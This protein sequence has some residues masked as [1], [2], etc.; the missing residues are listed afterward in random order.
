MAGRKKG[1]ATQL[2]IEVT[3]EEE[4]EKLLQKEGL[5][6][7][8]V[9]TGWCGPC[10]GMLGNLKKIKL[11]IGGELL[12]MA[13][14]K[15]DEIE[16][17][18]RF[19]KKSE[20]TWMFI[21][22]GQMVN[23]MFGANAPRLCRMIVDE[24]AKETAVINGE[25]ERE[26]IPFHE[27]TPEE[28]IRNEEIERRRLEALAAEEEA[29]AAK[30]NALRLLSLAR[31][32]VDPLHLVL[33]P[34][35]VVAAGPDTGAWQELTAALTTAGALILEEHQV[36]LEPETASAA[37]DL[38]A[39]G[40]EAR[41][42]WCVAL[43][44][45]PCVA[46][47]LGTLLE[48]TEQGVTL[49]ELLKELIG[50]AVPLEAPPETLSHK[51][52]DGDH[53]PGLWAPCEPEKRASAVALLF[54]E[55]Q[56]A[57]G[58]AA[59][60]E[61]AVALFEAERQQEILAGLQGVA[62]KILAVALRQLG[63]HEETVLLGAENAEGRLMGDRLVVAMRTDGEDKAEAF[64]ALTPLY[65]SSD[66]VMGVRDFQLLFPATDKQQD[67]EEPGETNEDQTEEKQEEPAEE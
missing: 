19:R 9:Y 44:S 34:P 15:A 10:I 8:D 49:G 27:L 47:L 23:L 48:T 28:I 12:H 62:E 6:V 57:D 52:K 50:P 54:P 46:L 66:P 61:V 31:R 59:P 42:E 25:R 13:V 29:T 11:E 17:L 64:E 58:G 5:I 32:D 18:A 63:G 39:E 45:G 41:R 67:E 24:L 40:S 60:V 30:L 56:E 53:I 2:Q 14:A 20:P 4:W 3:T 26:T 1:E 7:V 35:H 22:G 33:L 65:I 16:T 37:L 21:A 55:L 36:E 51:Y 38:G 43:Q